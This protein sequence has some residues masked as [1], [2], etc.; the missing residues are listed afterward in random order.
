MTYSCFP[1]PARCLLLALTLG[2]AT[3]QAAAQTAPPKEQLTVELT[4]PAKPGLLEVKLVS[5]SLHVSGYSG[6]RVVVE[7]VGRPRPAGKPAVEKATPP[8]MKRLA[9]TSPLGLTAAEKNNHVELSA[10]SFR[11]S[12]DLT[13]KVP[14]SFSL[15]LGTMDSGDVVVEN[16]QGELE[17]SNVNGAIV[18]NQVS[19]S[20]LAN[21]VNGNLTVTFRKVTAGAPM[22]FS[23]LT[24]K[25]DVTLPVNTPATLKV[26]STYGQVYSDFDVALEKRPVP[27]TR[28]VQRGRSRLSADTWTYGTLN[29]GG[30]EITLQTMSGDILLHKAK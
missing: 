7:A 19:G 14:L 20:A 2:S 12:V 15:K 26:K 1:S 8:G 27:A 3:H 17:I 29:G 22:A 30:A 11:Q 25:V 23:S 16:V 4:A 18:L 9:T 5:G 10:D 6:K 21:T 13:I 28:T 24:G